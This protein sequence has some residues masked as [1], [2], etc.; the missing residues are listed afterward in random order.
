MVS[1]DCVPRDHLYWIPHLSIWYRF[2]FAISMGSSEE[3]AWRTQLS[4]LIMVAFFL[5]GVSYSK[6]DLISSSDA[7]VNPV[8]VTCNSVLVGITT[9]GVV[10]CLFEVRPL[11]FPWVRF[12]WKTL[13]NCWSKKGAIFSYICNC[14]LNYSCSFFYREPYYRGSGSFVRVFRDRIDWE[15]ELERTS[16]LHK[17]KWRVSKSNEQFQLSHILPKCFV[18]PADLVDH[19]LYDAARHFRCGFVPVWVSDK[20]NVLN[21]FKFSKFKLA[22]WFLL[23]CGPSAFFDIYK[24]VL[25]NYWGEQICDIIII[26]YRGQNTAPSF[27]LTREALKSLDRTTFTTI[28]KVRKIYL[29]NA[30]FPTIFKTDLMMKIPNNAKTYHYDT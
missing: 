3:R 30:R 11:V 29:K 4:D 2:S 18:V 8:Y 24:F 25:Y 15:R 14:M 16:G 17:V 12:C 1:F 20:N 5:L 9:V 21:N 22:H 26:L 19:Q 10:N 13:T 7:F 23:S 6:K 28:V 27:C